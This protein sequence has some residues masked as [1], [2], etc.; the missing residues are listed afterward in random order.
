MSVSVPIEAMLSFSTEQFAFNTLRISQL[1]DVFTTE[2]VEAV[3]ED[4]RRVNIADIV[5]IINEAE[6]IG[7]GNFK[8]IRTFVQ[9]LISS[10]NVDQTR[11]RVGIVTYSDTPIVY[12]YLNSLQDRAEALQLINLIPYRGGGTKTGAALRTSLDSV[13]TQRL[14][15]RKDVQKVAIVITDGKSQDSVKKV[16]VELHRVPVKVFAIGVKQNTMELQDMA[17]Y[18]INRHV[19][20]VNSFTHLKPLRQILQKSICSVI[21]QGSVNSF[22]NSTDIKEA[23]E[24]KDEANI[25]FLIDDS[26]SIDIPD[27]SDTKEFITDFMKTFRIGSS[28]VRLELVKYSDLPTVQFDLIKYSSISNLKKALKNIQHVGGGT[29]TGRAL[30]FMESRLVAVSRQG[31]TYLIVITAG[32]SADKVKGPAQRIRAQNVTVFAVGVKN[33]NK[34]QLEEISGDPVR[35]FNVPDYHFLKWIKNDI[36]RQ[37]CGPEVCKDAPSDVIFLTESSERISQEDFKKMKEFM[38]STINKSIVGL[39]DMRVG[40]MQFSTD[41]K[42]EFPLNEYSSKADIL[43]AIDNMK[44][45]NGGVAT[46]RALSEVL[47]YFSASEGGRP[48]LRKNLVL[49]TF[50]EATDEVKGPAEDLRKSNVFIYSIGVVGGNYTQLSEISG[51]S[52]RVINE[53]NVDLIQELDGVLALKF[54]DPHRECKKVRK[55]D[56]IFLVDGSQSIG[57]QFG[58]MQTFMESVVNQTIVSRSST[59]FGAI[60]Y[61]DDPEIKF[62]LNDFNSRG[63]VVNAIEALVPPS[64]KTYTGKALN[65]ALQFFNEEHGGRR[66]LKVPQILMV[67]TDGE[68]HDRDNLEGYSNQLRANNITVLSIG[69]Q[70][71]KMD[72]LLI[73][74]GSN[75]RVFFVDNFKKLET[76]H[77]NLSGVI[78]NTTKPA[79]EQMDV[80]FLLDRSGSIN[81]SNYRIMKTFTAE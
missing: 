49:I 1:M 79:C 77:K 44:Q 55:A 14:G 40:V 5:F 72:E 80:V 12:A 20:A 54:C 78:C 45:L 73:M 42:L 34:A 67:I 64:K 81:S 8:L 63:E 16:A 39:D 2:E 75:E 17:S 70:N 21:I 66:R 6:S 23:C 35:T 11:V 57:S 76:L 25:F 74:A 62:S 53:V 52:D 65:Y 37:I 15:S 68:A 24:Q 58:S 59:R 29:N 43:G 10:L 38:K 46:G 3:T 61:S 41:H 51:F 50:S 9:S 56:I 7:T 27:L 69:V 22:K 36:L 32:R 60:L 13:F 19:F 31:P 4:C 28:Q 18:P 26:D 71:A 47:K 30:A 48:N 33:S